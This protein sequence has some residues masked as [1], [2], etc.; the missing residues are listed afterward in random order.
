MRIKRTL[1]RR[2]RVVR[3]QNMGKYAINRN[4]RDLS[5]LTEAGRSNPVAL[6]VPFLRTRAVNL[7]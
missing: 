1:G 7:K 5:D 4:L 6:K 2:S 3:E